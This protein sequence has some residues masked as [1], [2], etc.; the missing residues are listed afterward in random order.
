MNAP[1]RIAVY[2]ASGHTGRFVLAEL[3]RRGFV[4]VACGRN[5]AHLRELATIGFETR[6]AAIDDPAAL[7]TALAGC[8]AVLHCAGPFLDTARGMLD[9]A[10]RARIPYL[11]VA[12]E[13]QSVADTLSRD[14]EARAAGICVI[15]AMAFYGGLADLLAT[16][17]L[18]GAHDADAVEIAVALDGWHPTAGTRRTGERNHYPRCYVEHGESRIVPDPAPLRE[19]IFPAP[20]GAQQSVLCTLSEAIVLPHHITCRQLH[21]WMNLTPL[22]DLRDPATPPPHAIDDSR[23]SAQR[24]MVDVRVRRAG[25][26]KHVIASGRDIYAITAPLL[27]EALQRILDGRS[28]GHGC[29]A[30]GAAFE[31]RDFILALAPVLEVSF[32]PP[33]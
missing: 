22:R 29:L 19:I 21:S 30:P 18:G 20:F 12:A 4:P 1:L 23:R 8:A 11:D 26:E 15:P 2:G 31:A 32:D 25:A 17:A 28:R 33:G 5:P 6:V 27:V 9:A 16:A 13:Q 24:F 3:Q 7:D 10:L 14:D